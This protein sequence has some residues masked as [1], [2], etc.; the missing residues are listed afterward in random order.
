MRGKTHNPALAPSARLFF[1]RLDAA[2][3]AQPLRDLP[4][5]SR[6]FLR[7]NGTMDPYAIVVS[8]I[9]LQQTQVER[10]VPYF[11]RWVERWPSWNALASAPRK[12]VMEAW[13]GLGYN[14]RAI[15][16]HRLARLSARNNGI[17]P[18]GRR[19]LEALPGIGPYTAGAIRV[20]AF[21][22]WDEALE[23]NG[24]IVLFAYSSLPRGKD[25]PD[26]IL[27]ALLRRAARGAQAAGWEAREWY[28][29]L[30]DHGAR[31]RAQGWR[32]GALRANQPRQARFAGSV[33]QVRGGVV[34]ALARH[35]ALARRELIALLRKEGVWGPSEDPAARLLPALSALQAEG[36]IVQ[37]KG[38]WRLSS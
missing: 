30:M 14:R 34:R 4:W 22:E 25:T 2:L 17:L 35:G 11:L 19:E 37:Q 26:A 15:A 21:N 29:R 18:R 33:R 28:W 27:L 5:R 12:E 6:C 38:R 32:I 13:V 23:A 24:K 1:Q 7:Q 20:F 36:I 3:R 10:V 8:E 31:L 16:L 9:M